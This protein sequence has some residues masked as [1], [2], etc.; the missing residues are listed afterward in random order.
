[1]E[2]DAELVGK[3]DLVERFLKQ[4]LFVSVVPRPRQLMLVE[5]AEF[6]GRILS[7]SFLLHA[8]F[9]ATI[10]R[11]LAPRR[12]GVIFAADYAFSVIPGRAKRE[13]GIH[14][15]DREYG[16]RAS[17]YGRSRNDDVDSRD[18]PAASLPC[19]L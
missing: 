13:P 19:R 3:L 15:H 8:R 2:I 1:G 5:N 10:C 4:S 18:A 6:H 11:A 14:N 17:P 7:Y 12:Q 9:V 16:F